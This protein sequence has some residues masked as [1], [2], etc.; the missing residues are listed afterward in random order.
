MFSPGADGSLVMVMF[1][2]IVF[3]VLFECI[4]EMSTVS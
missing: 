4:A 2:G 1:S 3:R